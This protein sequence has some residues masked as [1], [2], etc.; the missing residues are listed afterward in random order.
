MLNSSFG[1]GDIVKRDTGNEA[2]GKMLSAAGGAAGT[3][4]LALVLT[5]APSAPAFAQLS[6]TV[7]VTGKAGDAEVQAQ[8]TESTD[9]AEPL[10]SL[11]AS[12][13]LDLDISKGRDS[14]HADAED[15]VSVTV[16]V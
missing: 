2:K 11:T 14:A 16:T 15:V 9:L 1:R 4:A 3:L 5:G 10:P 12:Q 7:T 6:S 8:G 13:R